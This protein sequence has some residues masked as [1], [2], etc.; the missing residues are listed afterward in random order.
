MGAKTGTTVGTIVNIILG[1]GYVVVYQAKAGQTLGKKVL[2]VK[3]VDVAGKT[4]S[5]LTFFLREVLGK[6]V[7]SLILLIG[8]LMILWD[9][10]K[11]GLHDKIAGTYVV[12][13]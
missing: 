2:G 3:V 11:Q 7:S 10:K 13:V 6:T 4:P 1:L 9:S 8:Y 12:R 5:M